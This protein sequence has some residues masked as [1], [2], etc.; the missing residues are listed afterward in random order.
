MLR[1]EYAGKGGP[2]ADNDGH[3]FK[4]KLLHHSTAPEP[5][6]PN[7]PCCQSPKSRDSEAKNHDINP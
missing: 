3:K 5:N 6:Q 4:S 7:A 2:E 1:D